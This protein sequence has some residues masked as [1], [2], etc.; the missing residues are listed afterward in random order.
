MPLAL[1][2][3]EDFIEMPFVTWAGQSST[4]TASKVRAEL[5]APSPD[6]FIGNDDTA[7]GQ[8]ELYVPKAQTEH[9]VEP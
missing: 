5:Q 4:D 6:A 3:D 1:D 8:Q 9:V 7:L 2:A